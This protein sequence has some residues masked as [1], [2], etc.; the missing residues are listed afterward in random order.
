[1]HSDEAIIWTIPYL[2]LQYMEA[3]RY[4]DTEP[5]KPLGYLF[6]IEKHATRP[7]T[8]SVPE[9]DVSVYW[10]IKTRLHGQQCSL[11]SKLLNENT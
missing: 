5:S 2:N 11:H 3:Q 1:M 10:I 4:T 9:T 7:T 6:K 8:P